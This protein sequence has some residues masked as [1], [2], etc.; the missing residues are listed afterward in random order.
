M[1][2][3]QNSRSN[4]CS[5]HT[6]FTLS[7]YLNSSHTQLASYDIRC[8][9]LIIYNFQHIKLNQEKAPYFQTEVNTFYYK[10]FF[11][12]NIIFGVLE[13]CNRFRRIHIGG[14]LESLLHGVFLSRNS[15]DHL[16]KI[17]DLVVVGKGF[18]VIHVF[19]SK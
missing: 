19:R 4:D 18:T 12:Q 16:R 14:K 3:S 9:L 11:S 1:C 6:L 2:T 7:S 5:G 10:I 17:Q 13:E 15:P 8:L